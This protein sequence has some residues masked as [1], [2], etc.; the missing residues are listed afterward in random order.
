MSV[1][2][3][4]HEADRIIIVADNRTTNKDGEIVSDDSKKLYQIHSGLCIAMAGHR[5]FPK[6]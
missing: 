5:L 2:F 6:E 4:I 1:I 3:G